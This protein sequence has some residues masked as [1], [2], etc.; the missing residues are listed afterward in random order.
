MKRTLIFLLVIALCVPALF[1]CDLLAGGPMDDVAAMYSVSEPTKVVATTVQNI[2]G[3]K[4]NS[5]YEL[6]TGY[7]DNM[8]ASVYTVSTE[9]IR[10]IEEGGQNEEVK[11]L[12][13]ASTRKIEAIEGKG[14]RTNGGSWDAEGTVW[15]IGR[16]RMALNLDSSAV[17]NITYEN[18]VLKFVVP[19][20]NAATVLGETYAADIDSDV[21][22][23]I[24]DDGAVVTSVELHYYLAAK[25]EANLAASEMTVKVIYTYDIE[26]ITIE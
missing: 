19:K 9:E 3:F 25:P 20:E 21:E 10:S 12:I 1:S 13:K 7:V 4:L 26:R 11:D 18:H 24:V 2:D 8:A 22:I 15:T 5:S 17:E 6:V 16:G 23:T 14:S